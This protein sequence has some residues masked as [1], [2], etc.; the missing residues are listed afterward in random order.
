MGISLASSSVIYRDRESGVYRLAFTDERVDWECIEGAFVGESGTA[1][2]RAACIDG[3]AV[4]VVWSQASG[5]AVV[6]VLDP[7]T[8]RACVCHIYG[9][10]CNLMAANILTWQPP[11]DPHQPDAV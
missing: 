10:E 3:D 8:R 4:L 6:I 2:Y 5:E 1:E 7:T 9:A 11:S